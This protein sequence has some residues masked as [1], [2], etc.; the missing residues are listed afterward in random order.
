MGWYAIKH[1]QQTDEPTIYIYIYICVCVCMSMCAMGF[2]VY[3]SVCVCICECVNIF[4]VFY[5]SIRVNYTHEKKLIFLISCWSGSERCV[6]YPAR[7]EKLGKFTDK[8]VDLAFFIPLIHFSRISYVWTQ[9]D[10]H[11][12]A[13]ARFDLV[14]YPAQSLECG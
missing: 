6:K 10:K 8:Q 11:P 7:L 13:Q 5:M 12:N 14:S 4:C 3:L 2:C 1:N 9:K